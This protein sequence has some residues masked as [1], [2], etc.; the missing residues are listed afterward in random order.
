MMMMWNVDTI[1]PSLNSASRCIC[2]Q[3]QQ[4]CLDQP[5]GMEWAGY[6]MKQLQRHGIGTIDSPRAI[7]P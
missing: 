1:R 6:H 2:A 7:L 4:P 5:G 3:M